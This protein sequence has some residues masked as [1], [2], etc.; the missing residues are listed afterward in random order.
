MLDH[1]V[2]AEMA[3]LDIHDNDSDQLDSDGDGLNDDEDDE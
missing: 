2:M 1:T 3:I